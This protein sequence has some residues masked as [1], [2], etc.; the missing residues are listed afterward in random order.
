M[1]F[2]HK[3]IPSDFLFLACYLI[4]Q[5]AATKPLVSAENKS[6]RGLSV[7]IKA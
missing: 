5:N 2:A 6:R 4:Q 1:H 3:F 7:H